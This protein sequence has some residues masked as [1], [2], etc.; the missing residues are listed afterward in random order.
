MTAQE[1]ILKITKGNRE[2][3]KKLWYEAQDPRMGAIL[4]K[5]CMRP[6]VIQEYIEKHNPTF[7]VTLEM[8]K[9]LV[10][11][12]KLNKKNNK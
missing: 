11:I 12:E 2:E 10:P 5:P 7:T 9:V 8:M 4:G 6:Y 3:A 1:I